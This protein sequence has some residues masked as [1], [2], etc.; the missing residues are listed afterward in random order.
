[1]S[2]TQA[3]KARAPVDV[4]LFRLVDDCHFAMFSGDDLSACGL[5]RGARGVDS[6]TRLGRAVGAPGVDVAAETFG[7]AGAVR[8]VPD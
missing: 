6:D 8:A 2:R 3:V 7:E 1:M 5:G 4:T